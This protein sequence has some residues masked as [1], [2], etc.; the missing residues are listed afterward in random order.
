MT[1]SAVLFDLDGTLW[2]SEVV[3]FRSWQRI[4]EEHGKRYT[5]E[6]Y[7]TR[8]GT[9]GGPDP[10]DELSEALGTPIDRDALRHQGERRHPLVRGARPLG[11]DPRG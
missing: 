8:F 10:L 11:S 1:I 2:D 6:P 9:I 7:S 3:R 4:F 5:L